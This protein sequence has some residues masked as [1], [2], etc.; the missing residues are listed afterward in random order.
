MPWLRKMPARSPIAGMQVSQLP[1]APTASLSV[2]AASAAPG[3]A[4]PTIVTSVAAIDTY[5]AQRA[6]KRDARTKPPPTRKKPDC[7]EIAKNAPKLTN[8]HRCG[9]GG[10]FNCAGPRFIVAPALNHRI[11]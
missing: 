5:R 8:A 3:A 6:P 7:E 4:A 9:N 1:G 2:S 11:D 10:L